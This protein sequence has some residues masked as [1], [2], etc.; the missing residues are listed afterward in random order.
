MLCKLL[1]LK[2]NDKGTDPEKLV[3]EI[4]HA[5][6]EMRDILTNEQL[7]LI[8]QW[9]SAYKKV[10][11]RT[12]DRIKKEVKMDYTETTITEHIFNQG[13]IEGEIKGQIK[14]L[15]NLYSQGILL[16][17]MFEE[18]VTPLRRKLNDLLSEQQ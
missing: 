18:M 1:A 11:D 10:T 12:P 4:Y 5:A 8:G 7:L 9:V 2:A 6:S 15:E 17:E 14:T 16:K 3:Y 13:K